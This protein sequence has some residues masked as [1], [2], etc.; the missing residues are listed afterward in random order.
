[1][2]LAIITQAEI[3]APTTYGNKTLFPIYT[4]T[5]GIEDVVIADETLVVSELES[6]SV[7]QLQVH[8]PGTKPMLIPAGTL[9]EGGRQTRTVNVSIV[10][11]AGATLVIPV[12]CVESGRWSGGRRFSKS[13]YITNRKVRSAT[14]RGVKENMDRGLGRSSDQGK[15]WDSISEELL[16]RG[17]FSNS[18]SYMAMQGSFEVDEKLEETTREIL[19]KGTSERQTGI[20]VAQDGKVVGI[21]V[22]AREADLKASFE[23]IIRSI[24]LDGDFNPEQDAVIPTEEDVTKFLTHFADSQAT[25]SQG[26]GVGTEYHISDESVVGHALVD[27]AGNVLHAVALASA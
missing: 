8:N 24:M 21:E 13:S 12:S 11:P 4:T 18:S 16:S 10:V 6:A 2:S 17:R 9:L 26:V 19:T 22:F 15:V 14:M 1:M 20:A 5:E 27:E 7:P 25:T 3:G 23:G